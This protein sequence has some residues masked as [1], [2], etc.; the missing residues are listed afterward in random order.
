MDSDNALE[1]SMYQAI[2]DQAYDEVNQLLLQGMYHD[3]NYWNYI[4]NYY[5]YFM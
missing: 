5:F 2:S 4:L 1:N 3:Q